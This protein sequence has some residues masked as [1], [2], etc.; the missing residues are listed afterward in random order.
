MVQ[1]SASH[2]CHFKLPLIYVVWPKSPNHRMH[3]GRAQ[4]SGCS[5]CLQNL[6]VHFYDLIQYCTP[7]S[8]V[9]LLINVCN[10]ISCFPFLCFLLRLIVS[11][12]ECWLSLAPDW[13]G[14]VC[15]AEMPLNLQRRWVTLGA[16]EEQAFKKS[17]SL[18]LVFF[19]IL[20]KLQ[21]APNFEAI[22]I[23][24]NFLKLQPPTIIYATGYITLYM[25]QI[26]QTTFE[27]T[28]KSL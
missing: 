11:F 6:F 21:I 22:G 14:K 7:T 3:F 18:F 4:A 8:L 13:S 10:H 28:I 1:V 9:V 12:Y 16:Q 5:T 15:R 19:H 23:T 27:R 2:P 26:F 20:K 24:S 25:P 17:E